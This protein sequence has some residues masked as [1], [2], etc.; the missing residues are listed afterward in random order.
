M[1]WFRNNR[2]DREQRKEH[3]KYRKRRRERQKKQKADAEESGK[4]AGKTRRKR[5]ALVL[6][7]LVLAGG[8][9]V[10]PGCLDRWTAIRAQLDILPDEHAQ[11]GSLYGKAS[12]DIAEGNFWVLVNQ[13]PTMEEGGRDCNIQYENP[14]G[15]QYSARISLYLAETGELLGNTRRVDPGTYV[16]TIRLKQK[17]PAGE[18]P[19]RAYLELFQDKKP[20][21]E[22]SLEISLRVLD[23]NTETIDGHKEGGQDEKQKKTWR[24]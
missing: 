4:K 8:A 12:Q 17:L 16:E 10:F 14:S 11:I 22:L 13:I 23:E 18:Y 5:T 20:A 24:P 3:R 21:G 7:V 1:Q 6:S 15:N 19:V 2:M 9:L